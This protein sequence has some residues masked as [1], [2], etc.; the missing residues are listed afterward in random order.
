[1]INVPKNNVHCGLWDLASL[2]DPEQIR[3]PPDQTPIPW[4]PVEEEGTLRG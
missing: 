3:A 2:A 1:M 4:T